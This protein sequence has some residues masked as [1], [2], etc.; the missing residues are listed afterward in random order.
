VGLLEALEALISTQADVVLDRSGR[1]VWSSER[2]A[3]LLGRAD[4][5]CAI[6]ETLVQAAREL[7]AASLVRGAPCRRGT[8]VSCAAPDGTRL[9][10]ELTAACTTNGQPVVAALLHD[11]AAPS[12][13]VARSASRWKLTRAEADVLALIARGLSNPQ[14]A[15]SLFIS[16]ATVKTHVHRILQKLAVDSRAQ[17]MLLARGLR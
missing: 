17:A 9:E 12:S 8:S 3:A 15:K 13:L 6:P 14:I 10:A 16:P 2:A 1:T 11:S 4:S 5:A 7:C